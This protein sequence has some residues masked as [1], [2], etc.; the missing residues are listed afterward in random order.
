MEGSFY[1]VLKYSGAPEKLPKVL[2]WF[3]WEAYFTWITGVCLL[4]IVYYWNANLYLIDNN[5]ME[6]LPW[7]AILISLSSLIIGWV[8]Y[9]QMCKSP[10]VK[11]PTLFAFIG[12]L[13][14]GAAALVLRKFSVRELLTCM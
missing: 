13:L 3:K 7:Q 14:I 9:D 11:K 8:V 1:Q 12:F 6:L 4:A 10:L 5:V 2:H